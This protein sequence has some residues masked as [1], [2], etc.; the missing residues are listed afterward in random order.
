[1]PQRPLPEAPA[2]RVWVPLCSDGSISLSNY[3]GFWAMGDRA[4]HHTRQARLRSVHAPGPSGRD[5][6][7]WLFA[8]RA[9][10][11]RRVLLHSYQR[12]RRDTEAL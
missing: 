11:T 5:F 6:G 1:M 7:F 2:A 4:L 3:R 8:S 9:Q 10:D 12:G